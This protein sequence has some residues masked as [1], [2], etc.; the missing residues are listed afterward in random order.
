MTSVVLEIAVF[1]KISHI[2]VTPFPSTCINQKLNDCTE[3]TNVIDW[4]LSEGD[5][6][7]LEELSN[8]KE[9]SSPIAWDCSVWIRTYALFLEER[10]ESFRGTVDQGIRW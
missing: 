8:F 9:D 1:S 4:L 6:T 3:S 2:A 10:L 7:F 5:P